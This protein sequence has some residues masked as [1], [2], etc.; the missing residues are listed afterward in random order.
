MVII[1]KDN[2]VMQ[3]T[4]QVNKPTESRTTKIVRPSILNNR[5]IVNSP[6]VS[7]QRIF[8]NVVRTNPRVVLKPLPSKVEN[9]NKNEIKPLPLNTNKVNTLLVEKKVENKKVEN[10]NSNTSTPAIN[11]ALNDHARVNRVVNRRATNIVS[12]KRKG[13]RFCPG[14]N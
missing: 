12:N 1:Y 6:Q 13:C 5:R 7:R 11:K 10:K 3:K 9:K 2:L 8:R 4:S 14:N